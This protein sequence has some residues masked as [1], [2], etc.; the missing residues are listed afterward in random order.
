[1]NFFFENDS[2]VEIEDREEEEEEEEDSLWNERL[3]TR[4]WE[5]EKDKSSVICAHIETFI[6][7]RRLDQHHHHHHH[8]PT[9]K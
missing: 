7:D 1:L 9:V 2:N 8:I 3:S 5:K 4:A 6:V